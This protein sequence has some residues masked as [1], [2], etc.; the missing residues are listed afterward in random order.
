MAS[1]GYFSGEADHRARPYPVCG[2]SRNAVHQDP[3]LPQKAV[4]AG[5]GH[6]RQGFAQ[7]PVQAAAVI[8]VGGA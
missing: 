1:G 5:E 3:A 7:Y 8:V 2:L 4:D 6:I